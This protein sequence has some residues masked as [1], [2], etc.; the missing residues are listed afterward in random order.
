MRYFLLMIAAVAL[1]GCWKTAPEP[2]AEPEPTAGTEPAKAEQTPKAGSKESANPWETPTSLSLFMA[3]RSVGDGKAF[4]LVEI[5][6][7]Q[8]GEGNK[9]QALVTLKQALEVALNH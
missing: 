2:Q 3:R 1:V 4:A 9:Q 6:R 7:A 5:A 8:I